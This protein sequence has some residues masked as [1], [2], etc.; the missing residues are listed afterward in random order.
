MCDCVWVG[1]GWHDADADDADDGR[2]PFPAQHSVV[3]Y[4][5]VGSHE[6]GRKKLPTDIPG[7][8]IGGKSL[9][10]RK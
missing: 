2:S 8:R 9:L 1:V 5:G 7:L 4:V 3:Y 10:Q 6:H